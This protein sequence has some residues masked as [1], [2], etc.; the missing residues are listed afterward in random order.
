MTLKPKLFLLYHN[1]VSVTDVL[2]IKTK[3]KLHCRKSRLLDLDEL[4]SVS[5]IITIILLDPNSSK[6]ERSKS[7]K[8][9]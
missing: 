6:G 4:K 8:N 9:L 1:L 7:H 2:L 3:I 5:P